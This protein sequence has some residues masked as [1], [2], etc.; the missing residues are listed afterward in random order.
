MK[1]P[2]I[3]VG[4]TVREAGVI[5]GVQLK[6]MLEEMIGHLRDKTARTYPGG[7]EQFLKR[8]KIYRAYVENFVPR[9]HEEMIGIAEGSGL[10]LEELYALTCLELREEC[11]GCTDFVVT[12]KATANGHV[13]ACHNEDWSL[14]EKKFLVIRRS[15]I[16]GEPRS[17]SISYGG[18]IPSI[19]FN[20]AGIALTGNALLPTDKKYGVPKLHLV[21]E[22][23]RAT[24]LE[25]ALQICNLQPRASSFN[26]VLTTKEGQIY[27]FEGS[28]SDYDLFFSD[29]YSIHTNHYVSERMKKYE[30]NSDRLG[31]VLRYHT[32]KS[33]IQEKIGSFTIE[34][35]K[36]ILTLHTH[37]PYAPCRHHQEGR[38]TGC[39]VFSAI[40]DVTDC[41]MEACWGNPCNSIW[42]R[43]S[44]E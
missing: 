1:F 24:N 7:W 17:I 5:L 44:F 27:N 25:E 12:G 2:V 4:G 43:Y 18:I 38:D 11:K 29:T 3:D 36:E 37:S 15:A 39:T 14:S 19:G 40:V 8:T 21:R 32:A 9:D 28:A 31:S 35:C 22:I 41:Q 23:L 6:E 10:L 30:A 42:H 16:E 20:D 33:H 13:Y 26:N 34:T